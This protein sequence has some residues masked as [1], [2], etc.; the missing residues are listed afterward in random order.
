MRPKK[1]NYALRSLQNTL[2]K[3][4]HKCKYIN[5]SPKLISKFYYSEK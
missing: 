4:P 3:K 2:G 1:E 5:P